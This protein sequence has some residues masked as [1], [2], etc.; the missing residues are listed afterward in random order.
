[1]AVSQITEKPDRVHLG[2]YIDRDKRD[3]LVPAR[4][5]ARR[6][7]NQAHQA[8]PGLGPKA[9]ENGDADERT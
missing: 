2:A 8:G 5:K 3:Q 7:R 1:M 4:P 9:T 6:E